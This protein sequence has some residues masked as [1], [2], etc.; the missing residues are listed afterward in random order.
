[1]GGPLSVTLSD[2]HMTRCENDIAIPNSPIYYRRYVD[3]IFTRRKKNTDDILLKS[4]N[5]YH[6]NINW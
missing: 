5:S 6:G 1:M 4:M 2:I 3:D